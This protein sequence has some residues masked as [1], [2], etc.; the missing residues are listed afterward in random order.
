[1]SD[2]TLAEIIVRDPESLG[3]EPVFRGTRVPL[4]SVFENPADEMSLSEILDA[5]PSLDR[6]DVSAAIQH[7]SL[8]AVIMFHPPTYPRS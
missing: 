1:M 5:Y 8:G 7:A 3:G 4:A 2:A 6:G